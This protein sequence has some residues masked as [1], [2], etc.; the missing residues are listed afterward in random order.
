[1]KSGHQTELEW[2][3]ELVR[4]NWR[5]YRQDKGVCEEDSQVPDGWVRDGSGKEAT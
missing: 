2:Q 1:M 5:N 4:A 3:G